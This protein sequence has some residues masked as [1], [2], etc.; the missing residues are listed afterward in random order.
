MSTTDD[1]E[2]RPSR[3]QDN[4]LTNDDLPVPVTL[5]SADRVEID[6]IAPPTALSSYITTVYHF[7]CEENVIRDIQPAAIGQL[8]L[9]PYGQ[10]E[11]HFPD[12]KRDPSNAVN[13]LTPLSFAAPFVVDGPFHAIGAVLSPLGWA[14]LTGLHAAE[15]TNRLYRASDWLGP[16]IERIGLTACENYRTGDKTAAEC[17]AILCDYIGENLGRVPP[18]HEELIQQTVKWLGGALNPDLDDLYAT[19]GYSERQAQRLV[20]RYFGL[21]P[22]ALRRKYRALRSVALLSLPNLTPEF[23]AN[24]RDAFYDQSHM[25]REFRLFAG[26]TPARL[27]DDESPFLMEVLDQKNFREIDPLMPEE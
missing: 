18:R 22:L 11:M 3:A 21:S 2:G 1:A 9:F 24:V 26:R 17:G 20:E 15:H 23:E 7:R 6:Y 16:E 4:S 19:V 10:G 27:N 13:L 25:I 8:N 12:G 14:A 5:T